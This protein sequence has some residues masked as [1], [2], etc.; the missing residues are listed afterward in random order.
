MT[1]SDL[2][3]SLCWLCARRFTRFTSFAFYFQGV[4]RSAPNTLNGF[5]K[6]ASISFVRQ[7]GVHSPLVESAVCPEAINL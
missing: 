3:V 7:S 5:R 2:D 6:S 4:G 1:L